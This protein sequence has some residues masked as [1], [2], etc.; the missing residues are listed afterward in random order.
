M[1]GPH[2]G[3]V[4]TDNGKTAIG[5]EEGYRQE[6]PERR[7][8]HQRRVVV[9]AC[10]DGQHPRAK[11]E[12]AA[13]FAS[14]HHFREVGEGQAPDKAAHAEQDHHLGGLL[15]GDL[16]Q[17]HE[18]RGRPQRDTVDTGLRA[19][20]A[21]PGHDQAA[22]IFEQVEPVGGDDRSGVRG[23]RQRKRGRTDPESPGQRLACLFVASLTAKP[24]RAL[25]NPQADQQNEQRRQDS[26][27]K[28]QTPLIT[29]HHSAEDGAQPDAEW[30]DAGDDAPDPAAL[31]GGHEL[32]HQR[33]IDTIES[34]DAGSDEEAHGGEIDPAIVGREIEQAGRDREIEHGADEHHA[35]AD[36]IG[37][38]APGKGADDGADPR[39][40]EHGRGLTEGQFPRPDQEGEH[41]A[42]QEI[43]EEFE[44][45]ADDGGREDL[46]LIAG[47]ARATVEH[48]EHGVSPGWRMFICRAAKRRAR[49]SPSR[50]GYSFPCERQAHRYIDIDQTRTAVRRPRARPKDVSERSRRQPPALLHR[51]ERGPNSSGFQS[52]KGRRRVDPYR[53]VGGRLRRNPARSGF[54]RSRR[55]TDR[56]QGRAGRSR[57]PGRSRR[58][59]RR[60]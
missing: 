25:R 45:V 5:K 44:G 30:N 47:Q 7:H 55:R 59:A 36:A 27:R 58:T 37:Q 48:L 6:Q 39:T 9:I 29:A 17:Q 10:D 23:C 2:F 24:A 49:A 56:R 12:Q 51:R 4:G 50:E 22:R 52:R 13:G 35:A 3:S 18:Q 26:D 15:R 20:I 54:V 32:L 57:R 1:R 40:H 46:D 21:E 60:A 16:Q 41:E 11:A 19:G 28:Q 33:Q 14:P 53:L 8:P 34:A 42:D 38:P 31:R 43:V